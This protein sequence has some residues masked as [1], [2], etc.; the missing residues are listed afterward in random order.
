MQI[1]V[2][3]KDNKQEALIDS[4]GIKLFITG[5]TASGKSHFTIKNIIDPLIEEGNTVVLFDS[6]WTDYSKYKSKCFVIEDSDLLPKLKFPDE[7]Y[8]VVDELACLLIDQDAKKAF[9]KLLANKSIGIIVTEAHPELIED[10][11]KRQ[12]KYKLG[13]SFNTPQES[14]NAIGFDGC[15]KLIMKKEALLV[16]GTNRPIKILI[17]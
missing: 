6:K 5:T 13:F 7:A 10:N 17:D 15:E 4:Q 11:I 14:E 1:K 16:E 8:L 9:L 12:F 2:G 3:L